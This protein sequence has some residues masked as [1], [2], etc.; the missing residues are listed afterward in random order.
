MNTVT[1]SQADVSLHL[2]HKYMLN[3]CHCELHFS[4]FDLKVSVVKVLFDIT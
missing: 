2:V 4:I 1:D 3:F